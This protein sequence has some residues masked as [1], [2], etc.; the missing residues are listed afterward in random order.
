[1]APTLC[2]NVLQL[3]HNGPMTCRVVDTPGYDTAGLTRPHAKRHAAISRQ[4]TMASWTAW[5]DL[6]FD[7]LV[8]SRR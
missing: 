7:Y 6:V 8:S 4:A 1:M 2:L 5:M 3:G